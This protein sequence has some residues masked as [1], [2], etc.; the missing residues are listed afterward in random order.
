[1]RERHVPVADAQYRPLKMF[2]QERG[3]PRMRLH[4]GIRD[5]LIEMAVEEWP[6]GCPPERLEEVVAA[7]LRVRIR[8]R[9]GS[10]LATFLIAVM[11]NAI[12]KWIVEWWFSRQSHRVLMQGW[13]RAVEAAR[14][15]P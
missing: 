3:G 10:V 6:D 5:K 12:A 14:V 4:A 1:M 15:S 8:K 9:Y 11:V 2:V 13:H 7:R